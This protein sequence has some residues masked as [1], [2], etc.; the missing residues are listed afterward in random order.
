M[1][2]GIQRLERASD[3]TERIRAF[4][5][6]VAA[7]DGVAPF[8]DETLLNLDRRRFFSA[9]HDPDDRLAGR[10]PTQSVALAEVSE[11]GVSAELAVHPEHRRQ[12]LGRL[13][14][15]R[16][17]A[18]SETA[19]GP[20][21]LALSVWAHG[22]LPGSAELAAEFGLARVRTLYKLA[23]PIAAADADA[24]RTPEGIRIDAYRPGTDDA[25]FLALNARVFRDHPEQGAL[26]AAGLAARR[27]Q[28][29]F[30]AGAFL[31]ARDASSGALLG[32]NWL[33]L[34]HDER[35]ALDGEIYVIGV[36]E[37]AAGRGLGRALMRAGLARIHAAGAASTSLYV[38][39]DNERA[40]QLY[41]SL[42]YQQATVDAQYA[43]PAR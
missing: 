28:P 12:G 15:R 35:G 33:K 41:R 36:A 32:Y 18:L 17:Q 19:Q 6:E 40:L 16:L 3:E 34:E 4:A 38:E 1:G 43:S 8:N 39:G 10:R 11:D 25:E 9:R 20:R 30:D 2:K 29:W 5:A 13:L 27:A 26:D 7:H 42:G 14:L 24:G 21:E 22:D 37:E 23:R 31:L